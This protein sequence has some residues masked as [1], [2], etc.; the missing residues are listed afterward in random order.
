MK[1]IRPKHINNSYLI[2]SNVTEVD[3]AA[4]VIGTTY[5]LGDK[6]IVV[7]PSATVT[8]TIASPCVITWSNH[9]LIDGDIVIFTT[10]GTLPT[11]ITAGQHYYVKVLTSSTFNIASKLLN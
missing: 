7:S 1:L 4:W 11:G 2:S 5:A 6:V 10:T 3:Y 8:M 9:G